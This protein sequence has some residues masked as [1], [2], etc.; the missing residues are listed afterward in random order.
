MRLVKVLSRTLAVALVSVA[1]SFAAETPV[2]DSVAK[3][4]AKDSVPQSPS[5]IAFSHLYVS[6]E[7]GEIYPWGDLMDVVEN[8]VY[9]GLGVRYTY[10][11][12]FDGIVHFDYTY[13]KNRMKVVAYPGVHQAMGR[14]GLD[15]HGR[16]IR[17]VMIGGGFI[18]NWSRA[19]G[20]EERNFDKPGG[21][22][23]DNETEFGYFVRLNVP[24]LK[25]ERLRVGFDLLWEEL[26]TLPK[27]SNMLSAG[28]YAEWRLW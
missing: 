5:D 25:Y 17:P 11:E 20:G 16:W 2:Q 7:G 3:S 12:N 22:L 15:W 4:P 14:L 6:I 1:C 8:S 18:C 13:F 28:F 26:W 27:R 24:F 19:D 21:T 23:V 10:W 9:V